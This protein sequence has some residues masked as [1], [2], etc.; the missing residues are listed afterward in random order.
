M[1]EPENIRWLLD[2]NE[3]AEEAL[4]SFDAEDLDWNLEFDAPHYAD[5]QQH[6]HFTA[7]IHSDHF[8][9][10]I[11]TPEDNDAWFDEEHLSLEYSDQEEPVNLLL[12]DQDSLLSEMASTFM[13]DVSDDMTPS[14]GP[15]TSTGTKRQRSG[16]IK[17]VSSSQDQV[18]IQT[19]YAQL[20]QESVPATSSK[21]RR[22][23]P[24]S[25][26]QQR[27]TLTT[28]SKDTARSSVKA[29]PKPAQNQGARRNRNFIV[30]RQTTRQQDTDFVME[31]QAR[32]G[33]IRVQSTACAS[34]SAAKQTEAEVEKLLHEL[35]LNAIKK[36]H[37]RVEQRKTTAVKTNHERGRQ[38]VAAVRLDLDRRV[39]KENRE[40]QQAARRPATLMHASLKE[41]QRMNREEDALMKLLQEHN[42]KVGHSK[43]RR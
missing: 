30:H 21:P 42:S 7:L 41:K 34:S 18:D 43:P 32:P 14:T 38:T 12:E 37:E 40:T 10:N 36:Q 15:L 5:L 26:Q 27:S 22:I 23:V 39:M 19:L 8:I 17:P 24:P 13:H 4:R 9:S 35:N 20:C 33:L 3:D 16:K 31:N 29:K 25:G 6:V 11:V 1:W 2:E 28:T